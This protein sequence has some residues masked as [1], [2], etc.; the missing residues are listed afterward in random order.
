MILKIQIITVSNN[1]VY[2]KINT[3]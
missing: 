2:M 1:D 3:Q